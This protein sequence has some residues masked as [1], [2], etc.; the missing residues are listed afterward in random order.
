MANRLFYHNNGFSWTCC[1]WTSNDKNNTSFSPLTFSQ[2][3]S[4]ISINYMSNAEF[5]VSERGRYGVRE[6][7]KKQKNN[8]KHD[9]GETCR[10]NVLP[11]FALP[12]DFALCLIIA[13]CGPIQDLLACSPFKEHYRRS[14]CQGKPTQGHTKWAVCE[15]SRLLWGKECF[16]FSLSRYKWSEKQNTLMMRH[17]LGYK[18]KASPSTPDYCLIHTHFHSSCISLQSYNKNTMK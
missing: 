9:F 11:C 3:F 15:W 5:V 6:E 8:Q 14:K 12:S 2:I 16:L 13:A 1:A 7:E 10:G 4:Y 18:L 17:G